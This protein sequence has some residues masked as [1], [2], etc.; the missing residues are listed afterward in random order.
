MRET[1][2][3]ATEDITR[4]NYRTDALDIFDPAG[5]RVVFIDMTNHTVLVKDGY[6]VEM[7]RKEL[8]VSP[9]SGWI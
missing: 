7:R 4:N 9:D 6:R 3:K 8:F 5:E 2:G 1:N